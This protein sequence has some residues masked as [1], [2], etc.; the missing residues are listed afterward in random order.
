LLLSS[1]LLLL[2]FATGKAVCV[3]REASRCS[4]APNLFAEPQFR[5]FRLLI[6]YYLFITVLFPYFLLVLKRRKRPQCGRLTEPTTSHSDD[7]NVVVVETNRP[8]VPAVVVVVA[9]TRPRW[10]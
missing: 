1:P 4:S 6:F 8:W 9:G 7:S 5:A 2:A 10:R 3:S